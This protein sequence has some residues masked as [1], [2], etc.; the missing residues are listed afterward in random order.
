M[1]LT[2]MLVVIAL[3]LV[4]CIGKILIVFVFL[5]VT[6]YAVVIDK[7]SYMFLYLMFFFS[8]LHIHLNYYHYSILCLTL[9]F[10]LVCYIHLIVTLQIPI[11]NTTGDRTETSVTFL[12]LHVLHGSVHRYLSLHDK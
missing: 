5:Y 3:G 11:V 9:A 6:K 1:S 4:P 8:P 2:F 10:S 12:Q 7:L